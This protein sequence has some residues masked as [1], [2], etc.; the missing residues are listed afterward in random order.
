MTIPNHQI[1]MPA[2]LQHIA[3]GEEHSNSEI[4]EGMADHFGLNEITRID[5]DYWLVA[6]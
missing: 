5:Y 3:D 4:T 2:L 1:I 6:I